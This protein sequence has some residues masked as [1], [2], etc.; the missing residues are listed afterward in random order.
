VGSQQP[1][2]LSHGPSGRE[3]RREHAAARQVVRISRVY[4]LARA[5]D[6]QEKPPD[7]MDARAV[8]A[9]LE[10]KM[11]RVLQKEEAWVAATAKEQGAKEGGGGGWLHGLVDTILGNL[12]VSIEHVHV[13]FE[14]EP[15]RRAQTATG[16]CTKAPGAETVIALG[17]TMR[18]L[19]ADSV[20]AEGRP[21]FDVGGLAARLYK[22]AQ[23]DALALY[24]D[25]AA[26]P[27]AGKMMTNAA[28]ATVSA[29][30]LIRWFEEEA[31]ALAKQ[32]TDP[33][34]RDT[35]L[36]RPVRLM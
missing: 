7:A 3:L 11:K 18:H 26:T 12:Q 10:A 1:Q 15:F 8:K 20:D 19:S 21:T 29:A 6:E 9:A 16:S 17:L 13:R 4:V 31:A 24:F 23:L 28:H 22:H 35:H 27:L 14:A 30:E 36:M 25:P 33:A 34:Q 32:A 5:K 2:L